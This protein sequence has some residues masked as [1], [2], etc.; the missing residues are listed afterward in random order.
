MN[1]ICTNIEQSMLEKY[2][3]F[4]FKTNNIR[5]Y[6][7]YYNEWLENVTDIQL[8]YFEKE[9]YNLIK[10]GKYDPER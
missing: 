3:E 7:K 1:K 5:K 9:M 2:L 4:R 10:Q 8:Q 6:E